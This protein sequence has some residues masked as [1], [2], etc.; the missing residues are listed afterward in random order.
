[1]MEERIRGL[2]ANLSGNVMTLWW[3]QDQKEAAGVVDSCPLSAACAAGWLA[4]GR[5][6]RSVKQS[7]SG[8]MPSTTAVAQGFFPMLFS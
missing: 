6:K 3:Q 1:M 4:R 8:S 2:A 7:C 5:G